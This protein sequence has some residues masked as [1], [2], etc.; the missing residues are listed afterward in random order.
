[1]HIFKNKY[2]FQHFSGMVFFGEYIAVDVEYW[3]FKKNQLNKQFGIKMLGVTVC[4][5]F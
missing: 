3:V 2:V 5:Y 4:I 1:M